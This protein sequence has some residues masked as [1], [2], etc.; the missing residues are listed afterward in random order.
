MFATHG[1]P[2]VVQKDN[3]PP[4]NSAEFTEKN[5]KITPRHPKAQGQV[6]GFNKLINKI[7]TIANHENID[8]HEATYDMLTIRDKERQHTNWQ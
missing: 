8:I 1:V 5:R 4:F 6:E 2:K 7:A 3:G